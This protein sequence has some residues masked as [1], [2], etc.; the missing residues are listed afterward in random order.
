MHKT[1]DSVIT[2][3]TVFFNLI[4]KITAALLVAVTLSFCALMPSSAKAAAINQTVNLANVNKNQRGS[5]YYWDNINDTLTLNR[6]NIDT[7]DDYGLKLPA[8]ATVV[9]VGDNSISASKAALVTTGTTIFKGNGSLT[10]VS[11]GTGVVL[12][13]ATVLGKVSFLSGSYKIS[14]GGDGIVSENVRLYISGGK[15]TINCAPQEAYAIRSRLIELNNTNLTANGALYSAEPMVLNN[16]GLEITASGIDALQTDTELRITN[17]ALKSGD[18]AASASAAAENKYTGGAYVFTA[19]TYVERKYS[20][21]FGGEVP[22]WVD[23]IVFAVAIAALA[24][25]IAL[26]LAIRR[27]KYLKRLEM[28]KSSK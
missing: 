4:L 25:V 19:P 28:L 13:D 26:P 23:Y 24:A 10:I 12:S 18:S 3:R 22:A 6:L 27:R 5:G 1:T 14:S 11:D 2:H 8:G 7:K 21:V 20:A 16:T 17:M 9:L 15:M